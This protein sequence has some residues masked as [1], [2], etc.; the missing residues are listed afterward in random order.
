MKATEIIN[1]CE[2]ENILTGQEFYEQ[3]SSYF[4]KKMK[5]IGATINSNKPLT[6]Q[7][8]FGNRNDFNLG[9]TFKSQTRFVR[10]YIQKLSK[11]IQ[12]SEIS[13]TSSVTYLFV[14]CDGMGAW[15]DYIIFWTISCSSALDI[16]TL[17]VSLSSIEYFISDSTFTVPEKVLKNVYAKIDEIAKAIRLVPFGE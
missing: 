3:F 2:D 17:D 11:I 14:Y 9:H 16:L 6:A 5:N 8:T 15:K 4:I 10:K 7:F 12:G 1:L 13:Q